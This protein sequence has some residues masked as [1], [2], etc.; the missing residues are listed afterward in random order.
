MAGRKVK[1]RRRERRVVPTLQGYPRGAWKAYLAERERR[2]RAGEAVPAIDEIPQQFYLE[3]LRWRHL[4]PVADELGYWRGCSFPICR[5]HRSCRAEYW[6][7]SECEGFF[8][9]RPPCCHGEEE[10]FARVRERFFKKIGP[11]PAEDQ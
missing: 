11:R 9:V 10:V 1:K 2:K 5:R 7:R 4:G 3:I 6:P 8:L